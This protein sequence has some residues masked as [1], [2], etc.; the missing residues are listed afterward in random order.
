MKIDYFKTALSLLL[1]LL[2]CYYLSQYIS[3][4]RIIYLII[5]FVSL[6]LPL[7]GIVAVSF[8]YGRTTA[9]AKTISAIFYVLSVSIQI[10]LVFIQ[11][12]FP[13]FLLLNI[14]SLVVYLLVIF[15]VV[16][17]KH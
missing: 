11:V 6:F 15:S 13:T 7:T 2:I 12:K 5:S 14:G 1:S 10:S 3:D 4:F 17:S 16:K 9:L 8:E